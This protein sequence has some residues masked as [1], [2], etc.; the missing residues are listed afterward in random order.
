[1]RYNECSICG[2]KDG[3]AGMLWNI[4]SLDLINACENCY[5]TKK[6]GTIVLH[7]HLIRTEEEIKRTINLLNQPIL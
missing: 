5:Q 7:S 1:M 6:T 3:R 2:A 4:H